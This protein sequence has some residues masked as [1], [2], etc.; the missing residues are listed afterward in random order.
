MAETAAVQVGI[1][2]AV[3]RN[4]ASYGTPTWVEITLARN[5]SL[6]RKW[7]YADASI[8][9]TKAELQAK[10]QIQITGQI[11]C[12]ADPADAGYQALFDAANSDSASAP[13]LMILDG[14]ITTEGV[15]GIR[16]HLNLDEDQDHNI[17]GVVYGVFGFNTAWHSAGYPSKVEI[18]AGPAPVYTA[19]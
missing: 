10:T 9:A 16:A 4:T 1:A 3:Y 15:K 18:G 7:K 17:D 8:R 6:S 5:S 14:D 2:A 13:D 12:R 19:F 11:E